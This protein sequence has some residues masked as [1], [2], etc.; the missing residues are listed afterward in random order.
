MTMIRTFMDYPKQFPDLEMMRLPIFTTWSYCFKDVTQAKVLDFANQIYAHGYRISQ[1]QIDDKWEAFYGDLEFDRV[2]FPNV[3][4]LVDELHALN[5]SV[6]LWVHPF[7]NLDSPSFVDGSRKGYWVN[8][9]T[10]KSPGI[11]QWWNGQCSILG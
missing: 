4:G 7:C 8:D 10:G 6:K 3:S 5:M 1:I 11:T 2:K 9:V